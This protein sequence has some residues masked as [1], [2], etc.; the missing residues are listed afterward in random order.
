MDKIIHTYAGWLSQILLSLSCPW[1]SFS[2]F[3]FSFSNHARYGSMAYSK[4]KNHRWSPSILLVNPPLV[5]PPLLQNTHTYTHT[6]SLSWSNTYTRVVSWA[7][8]T[9]DT[10]SPELVP[11]GQRFEGGKLLKPI[12]WGFLKLR[13]SLL[14]PNT[15]LSLHLYKPFYSH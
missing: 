3:F 13:R 5:K 8:L 1:W 9:Q 15:E 10:A 12:K 14:T 4:K 6:Q 11:E 2:L 7:D